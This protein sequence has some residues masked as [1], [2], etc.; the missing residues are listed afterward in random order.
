MVAG[1]AAV[2]TNPV[3]LGVR[4]VSLSFQIGA[5]KGAVGARP[6]GRA[7]VDAIHRNLANAVLA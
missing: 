5:L 2:P 3:A 1:T 7:T 6:D 4:I